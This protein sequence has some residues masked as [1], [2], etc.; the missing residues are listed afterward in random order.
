MSARMKR[1]SISLPER[2]YTE[3]TRLS[4]TAQLSQG[5]L[6]RGM[7]DRAIREYNQFLVYQKSVSYTTSHTPAFTTNKVR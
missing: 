6:L 7:I 4:Q 3:F 1:I 2:M 5:E